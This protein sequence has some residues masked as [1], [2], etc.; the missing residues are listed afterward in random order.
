MTSRH[1]DEFERLMAQAE[2]LDDVARSING[3]RSGADGTLST[4]DLQV[5]ADALRGQADLLREPND[6]T[7]HRPA[8]PGN[9]VLELFVYLG[10]HLRP[11]RWKRLF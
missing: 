11:S 3:C 7:N 5:R 6:W 10:E 2:I 4:E 1:L 8:D 9:T